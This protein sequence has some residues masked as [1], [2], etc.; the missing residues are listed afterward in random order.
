MGHFGAF[1][2]HGTKT[3]T[4]GEGGIFVTNDATLYEQVLCLSEIMDGPIQSKQFWPD[5]VGLSTK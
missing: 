4:T 3:I 5:A 2:F 1:S